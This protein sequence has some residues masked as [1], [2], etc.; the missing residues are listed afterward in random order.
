MDQESDEEIN[1]TDI[2]E[3]DQVCQDPAPILEVNLLHDH[4]K[5][6]VTGSSPALTAYHLWPG[7]GSQ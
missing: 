3:T 4:K 7:P 5:A 1:V 6:N 2:D